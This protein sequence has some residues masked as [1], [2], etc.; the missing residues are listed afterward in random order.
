MDESDSKTVMYD[1]EPLYKQACMMILSSVCGN[2]KGIAKDKSPL[3][4]I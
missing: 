3:E 2:N 1:N 4:E